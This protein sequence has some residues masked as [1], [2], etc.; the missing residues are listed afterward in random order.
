MKRLTA[1]IIGN[2][3]YPATGILKNPTH[4]ADDLSAKLRA[5]GFDVTTVTDAS[6]AT[7]DK[8]LK[9]FQAACTDADIALFFFAGHGIQIE[10][11]NYLIALDTKTDD[12][13]DAKFSSLP[14]NK[15]IT[16]MDQ[17]NSSTSIIV[18]D[19]CRNNPWERRWRGGELRGMAPVYA[20]RGTLIAYS[21]SPGE[22]AADGLGR[23][24][25]YTAALL[26]HID[27]PDV[28]VEAMFKRVRNTLSA[29]TGGKQVSWEHT[30]LA[31]E[32]YFNLSVASRITDYGGSAIKDRTFVL[33]ESDPVHAAIKRLK[34]L[35]WGAQNSAFDGLTAAVLN[36]AS[37]DSLFVLGRNI[38]QAAD[39][40]ANGAYAF[41]HDY[42][43]RMAGVTEEKRQA[44]TDGMLFEI[45]FDPHGERRAIPKARM[46]SK[47][48][49]LMAFPELSSDFE[50]IA[51]CLAPEAERYFL[52]PGKAHGISI[53]ITLSTDGENAV[54]DVHVEGRSVLTPDDPAW[55][56]QTRTYRSRNRADFEENLAN[57]M[58]VP[59]GLAK[60]SYSQPVATIAKIKFPYGFSVSKRTTAAPAAVN[61][62]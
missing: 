47:V 42:M 7:M 24:G 25:A 55:L 15:V 49:D 58:L 61:T 14:L 13:T 28:P 46:F 19:A 1:L 33:D 27:T 16:S 51:G 40:G 44:V 29:T 59:L 6:V 18:L 43:N 54:E 9:A 20:P 60:F 10:G 21:T 34:V 39:G 36:K 37:N 12:E 8:A 53:D 26:Q 48:F 4:D 50:F 30:S 32:F 45:F 22:V 56:G 41:V 17:A 23:N 3:A 35:T 11:D 38:L 57:E 62:A 5:S 31:G 52:L 2:A